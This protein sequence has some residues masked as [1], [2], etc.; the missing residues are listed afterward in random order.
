MSNPHFLSVWQVFVLAVT[1]LLLFM[2][3]IPYWIRRFDLYLPFAFTFGVFKYT[4]A[5]IFLVALSFCLYS[6]F[7]LVKKTGGIPL[8]RIKGGAPQPLVTNGPYRVVRNPQ[9]CGAIVMLLG[10]TIYFESLSILMY[11]IVVAVLSHIHV[12]FVEEKGLKKIGTDYEN[13]CKDV[14]RWIP[15]F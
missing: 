4:G 6:V 8:D 11:T 5:V 15:K 9:Q 2:F 14:P 13:Y 3:F 10:L 1:L 12:V 7:F